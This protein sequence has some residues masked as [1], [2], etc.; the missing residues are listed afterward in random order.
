M[1]HLNVQ[2]EGETRR[3]EML[4]QEASGWFFQ[5]G[6]KMDRAR[7]M[8]MARCQELNKLTR[9]SQMAGVPGW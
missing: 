5:D 4:V 9:K 6:E 8:P 1:H 2:C 7:K 3:R